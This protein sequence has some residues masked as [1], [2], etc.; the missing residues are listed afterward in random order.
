MTSPLVTRAS[1]ILVLAL[2][3]PLATPGAVGAAARVTVTAT[4]IPGEYAVEARD[5][6]DG[7]QISTWLTGPNQEVVAGHTYTSNKRGNRDFTIFAPRYFQAG[8]WAI[9]VRGLRT[10]RQATA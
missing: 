8:R 10:G 3:L 7:E 9:T 5:F 4:A 2:L 1:L 6:L